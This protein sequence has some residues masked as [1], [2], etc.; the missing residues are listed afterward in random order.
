MTQLNIKN[1]GQ[2]KSANIDFGDLT[3]FVGSQATG[4]S[5]LLQLIKLLVDGE[6]IGE[7]LMKHGYHWEEDVSNF[8]ELYF[9]QGMRNLWSANTEVIIDDE[10]IYLD[11]IL[12]Y[13]ELSD[14]LAEH[15]YL[16][17]PEKIFFIPAQRVLTIEK[18]W[19]RAFTSFEIGD[20]YVVCKFSEHLRLLMQQGFMNKDKDNAIF[21]QIGRLRKEISDALDASIFHGAKVELNTVEMRK[22]IQINVNGNL[23]PFMA[24]SAGQREF[25]PLLLGLYWLMPVAEDSKKSDIDWVVIEEPEMGLHP[26]AILSVILVCLELLHRGYRLLISTHSPVLLEAVWA[27]RN[28]QNNNSDVKYLYQLFD[29]KPSPSITELFENILKNKKFSTYYFDQ[30]E[31]GVEVRDISSLDPFDEDL[32]TADWGGLTG[33]SSRASEVVSQAI[34]DTL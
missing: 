8:N 16:G 15:E 27:I 28:L 21:P 26:R 34:Q 4:K 3:L 1:L 11:T 18:G 12:P 23:L 29:L 32:S 33:F 5:I 6:N 9:G 14:E 20:P 24:W 13:V 19:P 10:E 30:K 2:I 31:D 25:M 7:T 17:D 22:R